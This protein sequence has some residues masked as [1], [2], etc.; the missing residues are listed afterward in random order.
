MSWN[1][2]RKTILAF[3]GNISLIFASLLFLEIVLQLA[4]QWSFYVDELTRSPWSEDEAAPSRFIIDPRNGYTGD[5]SF[6]EHDDWGF[7]NERRPIEADI[8]TLGDSW[9]Y[10]TAVAKKDAWPVLLAQISTRDIYNMGMGGTGLINY[11][12]SFYKSLELKPKLFIV[13][14]YFG[15]DFIVT[16][17][18]FNMDLAD[19]VFGAAAPQLK[20]AVEQAERTKPLN[21]EFFEKCG[22]LPTQ[23]RKAQTSEDKREGYL[24]QLRGWFS[25]N[26]RLYGMLRSLKNIGAQRNSD[27]IHLAFEKQ[28][29]QLNEAQHRICY[30]FSDGEWRT[31]FQNAWRVRTLNP[32]D[33]RVATGLDVAKKVLTTMNSIS[34]TASA[35]LIVVLFPTKESAFSNHINEASVSNRAV[36]NEFRD[37]YDGEKLIKENLVDFL[38]EQNID[39]IDMLPYLQEV[40]EQPFF[41]DFD[42]HPNAFGNSIIARAVHNFLSTNQVVD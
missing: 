17:R 5:P 13:A 26:S 2:H 6:P 42:S 16:E 24:S 10:G 35:K 28:S 27:D 11:L 39:S 34:T 32:S 20:T 33:V 37:I 1:K 8:V 15:N 19:A 31:I 22:R 38:V 40:E 4:S 23:S 3:L 29:Q 41:G 18:H 12:Q 30:P 36:L 25:R 14:L 7:R 21:S 9:T